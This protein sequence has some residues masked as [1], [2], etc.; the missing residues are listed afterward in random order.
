MR[1]SQMRNRSTALA[2]MVCALVVCGC[3]NLQTPRID[4][5]GEHLFARGPG[6]VNPS[7]RD[8]PGSLFPRDST[9]LILMPQVT[10]VPVGSEVVLLAAVRGPDQYLRTNQRVEWMLEPGGVGQFVEVDRGSWTDLLLLDFTW[11]R[12]IDNTTAVGTTSRNYLRLTRGT[13]N[14]ADD[15]H[16][17]RGQTWITVTSTVEGASHVTAHAPGMAGWE[18]RK[19][20][21]VIHWIDAQVCY[22]PPAINPAGTRHVFTTTVT[23]QTDQSPCANWLVRYEICGGPAAGFAPDGAQVIEVPTDGSGQASVE[24]FQQQPAPGT[25]NIGIQVIRPALPGDGQAAPLVVSSGSTLKTWQAAAVAVRKTGPAVASP[26]AT[27]TYRLEVSNPG[28]MPAGDVV[29]RDVVPQGLSYLDSNPPGQLSGGTIE[30]RFGDLTA[31]ASRS[32]EVNFKA[33]RQGSF[34][35]CAEVS[36]AGGLTARDCATTTVS[37]ATLDVQMSGPERVTVG[38]SATFTIVVTNR[39]QVPA[40]GLLIK[41]RFDMGLAHAEVPGQQTIE[42]DLL[43]LAPGQSQRIGVELRATRAGSLCNRVEVIGGGIVRATARACVTAVAGAVPPIQPPVQPPFQPPVQPGPE[44]PLPRPAGV[45]IRITGPQARTVGE[46]AEFAFD[47]TNTGGKTL[48]N[49]RVI[50]DFDVSFKPTWATA[51]HTLQGDDLAWTIAT[52]APGRIERFQLHC[53]C[54]SPAAGACSRVKVTAAEQGV[55]AEDEACVE[56]R[57]APVL[58]P[59][60]LAMTLDALREPVTQGKEFTYLIR[61]RNN[62]FMADSRVTV[63]VTLPP[64][65]MLVKLK[66]TGPTDFAVEGPTIRFQPVAILPPDPTRPL[67]YRIRVIARQA[68][69]PTVRAQL[70]SQGLRQPIIAETKTLI[71]AGP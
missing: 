64:E 47:V 54:L 51:E 65:L 35:N 11:P 4:P 20:S 61:V 36:A 13:P 12:K 3:T 62:G 33:D 56:I 42:R 38:G 44:V 63:E 28:D 41:D 19:Q 2:V 67:E 69:E 50:S 15:V 31:G 8:V 55:W 58:A 48:T 17:L 22:P 60:N 26:G 29:L 21:A 70:S 18:S 53:N 71:F 39:G 37:T 23:R 16:V 10:V 46:T 7:Y 43:D 40:T 5:S 32:V 68:G 49:L 34:T 1:R 6:E 59:A 57:P 24:I 9:E 30:W 25:N 66:T 14:P 27:L 52:L 45:S